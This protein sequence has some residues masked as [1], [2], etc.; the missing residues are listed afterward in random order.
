MLSLVAKGLTTGEVSAHFEEIYGA[1]LSKDTISRITDRVLAEMAE[2][3]GVDGQA[4]GEGLRRGVHRRNL[5]QSPRRPGR[6][7]AV[8]RRDRGRPGR[9]QGHAGDLGR[10]AGG[11]ESAKFWLQVLTELRN[12]GTED[13]FFIICDGLK[14][15][16]DSVAAAFPQATVQTCVIHLIAEHLQVLLEEVLGPDRRRPQA[17]LPGSHPGVSPGGV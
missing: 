14:G 13:V 7:P 6:Q 3:L 10:C 12:R 9:P 4:A 5:R 11:G 2:W 1:S 8:L 17:D 16:P 15:L